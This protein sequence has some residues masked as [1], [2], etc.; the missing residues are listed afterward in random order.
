MGLHKDLGNTRLGPC[1]KKYHSIY[2]KLVRSDYGTLSFLALLLSEL[3]LLPHFSGLFTNYTCLV[4]SRGP[5]TNV[6]GGRLFRCLTPSRVTAN[7]G[8][9]G[10]ALIYEL[11]HFR[12]VNKY[13]ILFYI[14]FNT[15]FKN[16]HVIMRT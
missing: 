4:D 11:F 15:K 6:L 3:R 13:I 12:G 5:Y 9:R 14:M 1:V 8:S 7:A 10:S 2:H 16:H